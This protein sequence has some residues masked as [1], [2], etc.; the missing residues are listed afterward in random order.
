MYVYIYI[1][2]YACRSIYTHFFSNQL[3]NIHFLYLYQSHG[4]QPF[5]FFC[6]GSF[7]FTAISFSQHLKRSDSPEP[8]E[9][10]QCMKE[11]EF[12]LDKGPKGIARNGCHLMQH[13]L[14]YLVSYIKKRLGPPQKLV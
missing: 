9:V 11:E 10:P 3:N 12:F 1:Y 13:V 4:L 8:E 5:F 14:V 2:I 6:C 7:C